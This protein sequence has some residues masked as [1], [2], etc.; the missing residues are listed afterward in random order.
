VTSFLNRIL[1]KILFPVACKSIF[2][3]NYTQIYKTEIIPEIIP[4]AKSPAFTTPEMII[5]A[6]C[7]K[8]KIKTIIIEYNP[9][10]SGKGAF[11]KPH[12]ILWSLYDMF[13]FRIKLWSNSSKTLRRK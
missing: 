7:L 5:R 11:G 3:L 6:K 2:D 12:D 9:R 8:L 4:L 10:I 13:R 1:L